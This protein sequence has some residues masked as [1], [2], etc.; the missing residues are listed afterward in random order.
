MLL[1]VSQF[2]LKQPQKQIRLLKLIFSR[3]S[4]FSLEDFSLRKISSYKKIY[5]I[6]GNLTKY[7]GMMLKNFLKI[8]K[9]TLEKM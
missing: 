4:R 2:P 6:Y 1:V 5:G 3:V 7:S 9:S 8:C